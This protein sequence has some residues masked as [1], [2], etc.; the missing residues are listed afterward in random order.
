MNNFH[1]NNE[2]IARNEDSQLDRYLESREESICGCGRAGY[3]DY[4]GESLCP[5]CYAMAKYEDSRESRDY[6]DE[7]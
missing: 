3:Y 1:R 2:V 6:A 4:L 7:D 5:D